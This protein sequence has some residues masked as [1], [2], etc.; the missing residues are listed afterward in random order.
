MCKGLHLREFSNQVL[1]DTSHSGAFGMVWCQSSLPTDRD[2][3]VHLGRLLLGHSGV[4][5]REVKHWHQ[6]N[7]FEATGSV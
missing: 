4:N 1:K 3:S 2:G 5:S 7:Q 6:R